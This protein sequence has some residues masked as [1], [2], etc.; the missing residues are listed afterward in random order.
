VTKRVTPLCDSS[1]V[2]KGQ[3]ANKAD[4]NLYAQSGENATLQFEV[5][6]EK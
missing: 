6:Q 5:K 2:A 1:F 4:H 3:V